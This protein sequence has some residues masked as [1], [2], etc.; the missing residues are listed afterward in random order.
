[1][2]IGPV[3]ITTALLEIATGL[4]ALAMTD[5][6][7]FMLMANPSDRYLIIEKSAP[8]GALSFFD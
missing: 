8:Y 1:M 2:S 7:D 4:E 3:I 6:I 5:L